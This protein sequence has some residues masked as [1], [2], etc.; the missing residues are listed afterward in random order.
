MS[1]SPQKKNNPNSKKKSE[2]NL[3]TRIDLQNSLPFPIDSL[4]IPSTLPSSNSSV[5]KSSRFSEESSLSKLDFSSLQNANKYAPYSPYQASTRTALSTR[6]SQI[7]TDSSQIESLPDEIIY[8]ILSYV[9]RK[10]VLTSAAMV[11]QNFNFFAKSDELWRSVTLKHVT[12][13][14][15]VWRQ[16]A[17][18]RPFA[19]EFSHVNFCKITPTQMKDLF[20][21]SR[22]TLRIVK[23]KECTNI[24]LSQIVLFLII[25]NCEN[26]RELTLLSKTGQDFSH[27][28]DYKLLA[29]SVTNLKKL[30]LNDDNI[31][32]SSVVELL[33][34]NQHCLQVVQLNRM[35]KLKAKALLKELESIA[36][37]KKLNLNL[38]YQMTD[39][40]PV[41]V[42]NASHMTSLKLENIQLN[43][44]SLNAIF[45]LKN[46]KVL[47]LAYNRNVTERYLLEMSPSLPLLE[48]LNLNN[49]PV[50]NR[51]LDSLTGLNRL[52][53]LELASTEITH[54]G[55]K[56]LLEFNRLEY[57]DISS[58]SI[59]DTVR[60]VSH[61]LSRLI[62]L[63]TIGLYGYEQLV[64]ETAKSYHV[65]VKEKSLS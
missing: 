1:L 2:K 34:S 43:T 6:S 63:R 30:R 33:A 53:N 19:L 56:F 44:S 51:A 4:S 59:Q 46:L 41:L 5:K 54:L 48:K 49:C 25:K 15:R 23:F 52:V 64:V 42:K 13:P 21:S 38:C 17:R 55:F 11:N 10:E 40:S 29:Q 18:A 28:S 32:D 14:T 58:N 9:P 20:S 50:T 35:F 60:H 45:Q 22:R 8:K 36:K 57:L 7:G 65:N 3:K 39:L 24:D 47:N 12:L 61:L 27:P 16:M 31:K 62:R 37:L 26:I